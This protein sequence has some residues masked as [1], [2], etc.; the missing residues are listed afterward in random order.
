MRRVTITISD[1][2]A[3]SLISYIRQQE[4]RPR[5]TAIIQAAMQEFLAHREFFPVAR[6]LHI[7]P[8]NKGSS[9]KDVSI[10][11]DRYLV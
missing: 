1:E 10:D 2:T 9:A 3:V 11:H 6:K 4:V 8:A 7:T 5:L